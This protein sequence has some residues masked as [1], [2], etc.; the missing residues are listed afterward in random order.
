MTGTHIISARKPLILDKKA[1]EAADLSFD[2]DKFTSCAFSSDGEY[3]VTTT[4][5]DKSIRILKADQVSAHNDEELKVVKS[6]A[7]FTQ[8]PMCMD[9]LVCI[10][11]FWAVLQLVSKV[12]PGFVTNKQTKRT[13][14]FEQLGRLHCGM[15]Q[16]SVA[17]FI[18][19]WKA[20]QNVV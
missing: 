13:R 12:F 19:E 4:G 20:T 17:P 8:S 10:L 11:T 6:A 3:L 5:A 15:Q 7:P 16:P 2:D 18:I 14:P 1:K 9:V